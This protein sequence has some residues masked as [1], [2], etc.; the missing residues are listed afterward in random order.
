[1][2]NFTF[3]PLSSRGKDPRI[4]FSRSLRGPQ[5]RSGRTGEENISGSCPNHMCVIMC[6]IVCP[7][8]FVRITFNGVGK[9]TATLFKVGT[10]KQF[11]PVYPI[12]LVKVDASTSI[13]YSATVWHERSRL[14]SSNKHNSVALVRERTIPTER[15][16]PVGEVSANFCG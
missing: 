16:P 11:F 2:I 8:R 12:C 7:A 9:E 13:Y 4:P 15:P 1:M 6:W 10:K 5:S 14:D 3:Q